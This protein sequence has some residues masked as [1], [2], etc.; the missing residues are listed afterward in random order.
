M[1]SEQVFEIARGAAKSEGWLPRFEQNEPSLETNVRGRKLIWHIW[2]S[3]KGKKLP[4][5]GTQARME[6][7]DETGEIINKAYLPR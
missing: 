1:T 7:D 3:L 5:K 6:I 4:Y 2:F